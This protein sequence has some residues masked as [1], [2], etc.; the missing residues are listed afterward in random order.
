MRRGVAAPLAILCGTALVVALWPSAA[1]AAGADRSR[2]RPG[3]RTAAP[4]PGRLP[5]AGGYFPLIGPKHL[6]ALPSDAVCSA[7]VHRSEWEPRPSNTKRNHVMPD[8][9]AVRESFALRPRASEG[10]YDP[11]WD[12]WLL[13]RVDGH[14]TG[15]TDEIFQWAAC[16]W[17]LPDDLLR[18]IAVRE[19]GWH[20]YD[21]YRRGR[22]VVHYGCGDTFNAASPASDA[23]CATVA[24]DGYD[25]RPDFRDRTCPKTFS[26]VGVMSWQDPAWGPFV[27]NQNGTFPYNRDSTAFAV[28]YLGASLRGCFQGWES[29]LRGSGASATGRAPYRGGDLFGCVGSW[30]AGEWRTPRA[31][32]YIDRVQVAMRTRPWLDPDWPKVGPPCRPG[33][34]CP[35]PDPIPVAVPPPPALRLL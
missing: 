35:G 31:N 33:S 5:P 14:F 25:Y 10:G 28:D 3:D 19:S 18:A 29:W 1:V 7:S 13:P 11:R 6:G 15:T 9:L 4:T 8:P 27:D 26:I 17:G 21:T 12:T 30:Y 22:C 32:G 16:K 23:Y 24:L 20:Q 34:G 2:G